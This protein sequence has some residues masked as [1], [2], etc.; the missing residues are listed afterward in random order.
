MTLKKSRLVFLLAG[1]GVTVVIGL[2]GVA[3]WRAWQ[4]TPAYQFREARR[5]WE[6]R[7][8]QHYRLA[9]NYEVNWAQCHYDI[10]VRHERIV[11]VFGL[12]CLSGAQSQTLTV[13]GLFENFERYLT[14]RVCSPNGCYCEGIYVV[15]A[16]YD[17]T[18][19]YPQ[20]ITT[21][22]RRNWLD[23]LLR[24]K[25]GVQEC[26]RTTPVVEKIDGVKLTPLP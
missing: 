9:A 18:W 2:M 10:E 26:L 20:R 17:P 24:G 14:Q 16:T 4:S 19:G 5:R 21:E 25:Q 12:T 1:I 3:L 7:P 8:F 13:G 15:K 22:F 11:H 6:A 23:D